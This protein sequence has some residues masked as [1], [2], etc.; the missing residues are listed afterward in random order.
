MYLNLCPKKCSKSLSGGRTLLR[1]SDE[2]SALALQANLMYM[3]TCNFAHILQKVYTWALSGLYLD[4][5]NLLKHMKDATTRGVTITRHYR[6]RGGLAHLKPPALP[7]TYLYRPSSVKERD[8]HRPGSSLHVHKN[9][10]AG[11]TVTWYS[12][13]SGI[14]LVKFYLDS[15]DGFSAVWGSVSKFS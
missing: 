11:T 8:S 1:G 5:I 6:P 10:L 3:Y 9:R 15:D 14:N 4:L 13:E 12:L 7:I 2:S